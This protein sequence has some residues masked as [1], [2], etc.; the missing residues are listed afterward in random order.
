MVGTI[1][2]QL[3]DGANAEKIDKAGFVIIIQITVYVIYI[4]STYEIMLTFLIQIY[5]INLEFMV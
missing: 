1:M 2:H 5:C 3:V 4:I